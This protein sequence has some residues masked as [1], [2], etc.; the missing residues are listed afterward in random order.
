MQ[1]SPQKIMQGKIAEKNICAH[2]KVK[3]KINAEGYATKKTHS[4]ARD[5]QKKKI[6]KLTMSHLH[7]HFSNGLPLQ[8][9]VKNT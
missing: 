6:I 2:R 8:H 1:I 5:G 9:D 3:K 4:S 7:H